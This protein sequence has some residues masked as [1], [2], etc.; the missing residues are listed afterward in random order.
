MCAYL[1]SL[2]SEFNYYDLEE[3]TYTIQEHTVMW[4][5][6]GMQYLPCTRINYF[7]K[8]VNIIGIKS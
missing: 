8:T 6:T 4:L 7:K 3:H 5:K 2:R 1:Q